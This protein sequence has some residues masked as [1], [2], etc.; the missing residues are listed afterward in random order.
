MLICTSSA[1]SVG[2]PERASGDPVLL[3]LDA[4]GE[5]DGT[6]SFSVRGDGAH[7][8]GSVLAGTLADERHVEFYQVGCQQGQ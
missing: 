5:H 6:G 4:L 8:P 7:H 2:G 1:L 3:G